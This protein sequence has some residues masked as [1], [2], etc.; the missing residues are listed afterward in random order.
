LRDSDPSCEARGQGLLEGLAL[1]WE[2]T[3]KEAV[4]DDGRPTFTGFHLRATPPRA[5]LE[6]PTDPLR[7]EE[8]GRLRGWRATPGLVAR[9]ARAHLALLDRG[10]AA[11]ILVAAREADGLRAFLARLDEIAPDRSTP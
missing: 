10:G 4:G 1:L 5:G 11:R 8:L 7:A 3:L 6:I 2:K 9:I